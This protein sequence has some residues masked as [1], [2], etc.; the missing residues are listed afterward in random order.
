M[1][2]IHATKK[3]SYH[4]QHYKSENLVF[5]NEI[6]ACKLDLSVDSIHIYYQSALAR[7]KIY[8]SADKNMFLNKQTKMRL[9]YAKYWLILAE[10]G[11]KNLIKLHKKTPDYLQLA[12]KHFKIGRDPGRK[13]FIIWSVSRDKPVLQNW[14][15]TIE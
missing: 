8:L 11:P 6:F 7:Y 4:N 3:N 12:L 1:Q 5:A 2:I 15:D 9:I 10:Y 14:I 13:W